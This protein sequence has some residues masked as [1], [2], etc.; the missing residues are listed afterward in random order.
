M[1]L[2][3][4]KQ[5]YLSRKYDFKDYQ[6]I[7]YKRKNQLKSTGSFFVNK[8]NAVGISCIINKGSSW[9]EVFFLDIFQDGI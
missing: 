6:A 9:C 5:E 1:I 7:V 2:I 8:M 3:I 4:I